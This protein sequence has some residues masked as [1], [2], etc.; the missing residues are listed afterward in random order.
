MGINNHH[1]S[2]PLV[3]L[4]GLRTLCWRSMHSTPARVKQLE[5]LAQA[6]FR[7]LGVGGHHQVLAELKR[8]VF[9]SRSMP[10]E[11]FKSLGMRHVKG[12]L[13]HGPPGTGKTLV[14]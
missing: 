12:V 4:R 6:D 11:M 13:L 9:A 8:R 7:A 10:V 5:N 2:V 1:M 14:A 3:R